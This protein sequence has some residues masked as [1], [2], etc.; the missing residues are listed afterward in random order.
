M[1]FDEAYRGVPMDGVSDL[2]I[3]WDVPQGADVSEVVAA[4]RTL[5]YDYWLSQ[6]ADWAPMI[7]IARFLYT[8]GYYQQ[9]WAGLE[10]SKSDDPYGGPIWVRLMGAEKLG[11]DTVRVTFCTDIGWWLQSSW[12]KSKPR[13]D[14]ANLESFV[15]VN[16]ETGDG[17]R[18]WLADRHLDPDA[19][20]KAVYGTECT[21]WAQ[22]QP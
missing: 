6:S 15:M 18:R 2:R 3:S 7:P 9:V 21:K 11:P 1:T 4:R 20:R 14:R 5:A 13:K 17:E 16:A 12:D 22:H 19:D 8:E 10:T